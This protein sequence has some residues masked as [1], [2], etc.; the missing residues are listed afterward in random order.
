MSIHLLLQFH[1]VSFSVVCIC[2]YA[3]RSKALLGLES[4]LVFSVEVTK[5]HVS[6]IYFASI[7]VMS[8]S[9]TSVFFWQNLGQKQSRLPA[10]FQVTQVFSKK[11]NHVQIGMSLIAVY[12][13]IMQYYCSIIMLNTVAKV[14]FVVSLPGAAPLWSKPAH[15][16]PNPG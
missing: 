6:E 16:R 1:C 8:T 11:F 9:N 14:T 15:S 2:V 5:I 3:C 4:G 12:Y 7:L 13:F 10:I